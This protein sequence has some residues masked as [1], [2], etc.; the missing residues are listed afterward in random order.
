[1]KKFQKIMSYVV[2]AALASMLTLATTRQEIPAPSKLEQLEALIGEKFIGESD[3]TAMQ[4]AAAE[5]MIASLGDRWSYYIPADEYS[6][7]LDQMANSYVGIGVTIQVTEDASGFLV[8]KVNEGGPADQAGMLPG[9]TVVA[10]DGVDVRGMT[11]DDTSALVKGEENTTV[12]I[13]VER[14]GEQKTLTV[15]R[16]LVEVPVATAKMLEGGI[17]LITIANF[18]QRCADETIAAMDSLLEQG[19]R[20]LIF[21]VRYNPG[22]YVSQLVKVLDH[23][24]PE[25]DLF[26]SVNYEGKESLDRSDKNCIEGIPMAVLVNGSSY[27]AAEFFAAALREYDYALIVGEPTT[28]KGYF[29]QTYT[30]GDGSAVGLSVGKYFTPKGVSLA[31][32]G[33]LIPDVVLE[34]DEQTAAGIYAGTLDPMEDPQIIAAINALNNSDLLLIE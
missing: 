19:A 15:T 4:D 2:V 5:A 27:S 1:M 32:A 26:R 16:M 10:V 18:D 14:A 28:G 24:L 7:Y 31:E 22:G 13:T 29:Q 12:E 33:G 6:D 8:T 3:S 23:I 30:L 11:I 17:G 34:V 21:D 9:D 25:G 20:K